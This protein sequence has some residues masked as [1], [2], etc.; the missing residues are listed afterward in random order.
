MPED[1]FSTDMLPPIDAPYYINA[2]LL[3][4][5]LRSENVNRM[6]LL[7][8]VISLDLEDIG[9]GISYCI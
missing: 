9:H 6:G 7:Y 2:P 5:A 8:C 3:S 4:R 1:L